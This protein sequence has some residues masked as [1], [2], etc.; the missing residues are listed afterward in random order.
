ME[1][2]SRKNCM[3]LFVMLEDAHQEYFSLAPEVGLKARAWPTR[4]NIGKL[5]PES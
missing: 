5:H 2:R 1:R 4:S 3:T